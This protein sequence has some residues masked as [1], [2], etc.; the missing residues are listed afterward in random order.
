ME[1]FNTFGG[2]PVSAAIAN[3]VLDVI[4][5]ENLLDNATKIGNFL[6]QE[7]NRLK[8][9]HAI[10]G[11]ILFMFMLNNNRKMK[12]VSKSL[13]PNLWFPGDVRG[14]GMFLGVDLVKNRETR[15][16]ATAEAAFINKR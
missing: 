4:E 6:K 8:G 5:K 14:E 2:N 9:K 11:N 1:Y 15:E 10:I 13:I 16:P 12:N 7:F 3:A